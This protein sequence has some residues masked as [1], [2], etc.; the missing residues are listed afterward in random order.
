[1]TLN[2]TYKHTR[3]VQCVKHYTATSGKHTRHLLPPS[4]GLLDLS[5]NTHIPN[6]G[7]LHCRG[8]TS[9]QRIPDLTGTDGHHLRKRNSYRN[10]HTRKRSQ[11]DHLLQT[12]W[13]QPVDP[14]RDSHDRRI[15]EVLVHMEPSPRTVRSESLYRRHSDCP[16]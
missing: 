6:L 4:S 11:R 16:N 13:K 5:W 12:S 9:H 7:P 10:I 8:H 15:R 1:M 3:L 14:A 2:R